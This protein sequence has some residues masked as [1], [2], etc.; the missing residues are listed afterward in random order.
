M[1]ILEDENSHLH[2]L[3]TAFPGGRD[4]TL[5]TSSLFLV[6]EKERERDVCVSL[7]S[8]RQA[9]RRARLLLLLH[10]LVNM[11]KPTN[12]QE[13]SAAFLYRHSILAQSQ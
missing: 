9:G 4:P 11:T 12:M 3:V 7:S 5:P 10:W 13:C 6:R 8:L 2:R 1:E